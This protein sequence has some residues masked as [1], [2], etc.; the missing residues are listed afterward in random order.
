MIL[1]TGATGFVGHALVQGLLAD[2][3]SRQVAVAVRALDRRWP[4]RV[5]PY[6]IGDLASPVD[7]SAVL[8]GMR[9]VIHCAARVHVMTDNAADPL[10]EFRKV[11]TEA[12]LEL[13]RAAGRAG[14][15]RFVF[16]S[17]IKVNGEETLPGVPFTADDIARPQD[18]C[19]ISKHEAEQGLHAIGADTGM[20]I[21]VVRPPLVYGAGVGGNFASMMRWLDRGLPL[22]MACV[23]DNRRSLVALD[24]LVDLLVQCVVKPLVPDKVLLVSDGE[25][26]STAALLRRLALARGG[27]ARL[28]PVPPPLLRFVG[29]AFGQ[30]PAL[31]RLTGSLQID[32][33]D[34]RRLLDWSPPVG[35]DEG[36]RRTISAAP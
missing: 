4:D 33:S 5:Q 29:Q 16:L 32:L 35:V 31:Q 12:T 7:W 10:A 22:P 19:A 28:Y 1:V 24:N 13:A 3:V 26:L 2:D 17:T 36:L 25:D 14:V 23:T 18:P 15:R 34:T 11:N 21:V 27:H 30:G 20:E 9:C 6:P 8:G